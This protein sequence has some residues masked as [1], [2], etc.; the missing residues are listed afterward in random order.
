MQ[1]KYKNIY[2]DLYNLHNVFFFSLF[3][4]YVSKIVY[5]TS[6]CHV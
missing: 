1:Y 2:F 5:F 4:F 3:E 6:K